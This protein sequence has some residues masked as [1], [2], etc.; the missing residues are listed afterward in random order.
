MEIYHEAL[1]VGRYKCFL[2]A[3][4][5]LP[6]VY[7]PDLLRGTTDL[8]SAPS[9]SLTQRTYNL[10]G[11][12]FTPRE[13]AAAIKAHIPHFEMEYAP[14]FRQQIAATWPMR[15]DDSR[16]R[17]DWG[18]APRYTLEDMTKEMLDVLSEQGE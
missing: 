15:L 4:T 17:E 10:N 7:M 3:D 6:M 2:D 14:D 8:M 9:D 11:M 16:A 5:R 1:A 18:W 13:Q 12:S